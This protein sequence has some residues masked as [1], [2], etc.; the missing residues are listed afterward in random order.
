MHYSWNVEGKKRD[1]VR[2]KVYI[3]TY[4]GEEEEEEKRRFE[5]NTI[6]IEHIQRECFWLGM[7]RQHRKR[8][9]VC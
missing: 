4:P 7:R 1:G 6:H 3:K 5:I 8:D 2:K 9:D